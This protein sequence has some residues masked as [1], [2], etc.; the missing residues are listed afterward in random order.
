MTTSVILNGSSPLIWGENRD[1]HRKEVFL[2]VSHFVAQAY[3]RFVS[4]ED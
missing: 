4:G 1:A 3:V 2:T